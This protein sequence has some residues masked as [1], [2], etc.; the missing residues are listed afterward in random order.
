[1]DWAFLLQLFNSTVAL[2]I[3]TEVFFSARPLKAKVFDK[4]KLFIIWATPNLILTTFSYILPRFTQV[5]PFKW[6]ITNS[7]ILRTFVASLSGLYVLVALFVFITSRINGW[8]SLLV[9]FNR[10]KIR[11]IVGAGT[12]TFLVVFLVMYISGWHDLLEDKTSWTKDVLVVITYGLVCWF[13][14]KR[15]RKG[16][17]VGEFLLHFLNASI[18]SAILMP[19]VAVVFATAF[20]VA[21]ILSQ[22]LNVPTIWL[23]IPIYLGVLYGPWA[24]VYI[25]VKRRCLL[26]E[27]NKPNL[28]NISELPG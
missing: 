15:R 13:D 9:G 26:L 10:K 20:V 21:I 18:E 19:F 14:V 27:T 4:G 2:V 23:N 28:S 7:Y 12:G 11:I 16:L 24:M 3:G 17:K 6:I 25:I 1:M 8:R 5:S 22:T